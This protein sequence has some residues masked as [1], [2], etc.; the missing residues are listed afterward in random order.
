MSPTYHIHLCFRF[1]RANETEKRQIADA[2]IDSTNEYFFE[3]SASTFMPVYNYYITG[4]LHKPT[5]M[6][7]MD[8]LNEIQYWELPGTAVAECCRHWI[9]AILPD[10]GM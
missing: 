2:Y 6:C 5:A 9:T 3:R 1:V 4:N 8:F 7:P 10:E